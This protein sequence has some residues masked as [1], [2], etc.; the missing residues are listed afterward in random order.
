M[1]KRKAAKPVYTTVSISKSTK[2][3]LAKLC[4]KDQRYDDLLK[5]LIR[6]KREKDG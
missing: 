1:P 2:K 4:R 6:L 3:E 5:E